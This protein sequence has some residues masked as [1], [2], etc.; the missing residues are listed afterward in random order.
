MRNSYY[1]LLALVAITP[2]HAEEEQVF[3]ISSL[4]Q[5]DEGFGE[6]IL[7]GRRQGDDW[8]AMISPKEGQLKSVPKLDF[9]A[10]KFS[11]VKSPNPGKDAVSLV[12]EIKIGNETASIFILSDITDGEIENH[13]VDLFWGPSGEGRNMISAE[14]QWIEDNDLADGKAQ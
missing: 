3:E 7:D 9:P 11:I 5:A 8:S 14:C 4:C 12:Q 2:V 13:S 10:L 6:F 1:A